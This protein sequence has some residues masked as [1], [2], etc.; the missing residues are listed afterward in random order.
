MRSVF[1]KELLKVGFFGFGKSSL[2]VYEYLKRHCKTE[3]TVRSDT[4]PHGELPPS[5]RLL[6][7][8]LAL[9]DIDEDILF[10]SPSVRRDR[11][12]LTKALER[13]VILSS[14]S[15]LFFEYNENDVYLVTGS[16][17]K[18]TTTYITAELLKN[19][20]GKAVPAGNFG[21]ALSPHIDDSPDTALVTELSSFQLNYFIPKSQRALITN[22]TEN[23]LNW[24]KSY[25]EYISA[26]KNALRLTDGAIL[27]YDNPQTRKIAHELSSLY[28]VFSMEK[29]EA[30]LKEEI[31]AEHYITLRDGCIS[32]S[33][34]PIL[35]IS[36][37][38]ARGRHN[39]LNFM[40]AIALS[41]GKCDREYI[42]NFAESFGGLVH[43]CETVGIYRGVRY[44]NSSIDSSPKRTVATLATFSD[45]VIIIL[46]GRGK[47]LDF[48]ELVPTLREKTKF[49]VLTG[50]CGK[51]IKEILD[52]ETRAGRF[53]APYRYESDFYDALDLAI[54]EASESDTVLLSPA[55]TSYDC[56]KSFEERGDAFK[57]YIKK[58]NSK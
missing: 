26:K 54:R 38:K 3:I 12:E 57:R 22:I 30:E 6:Y 35:P 47:G 9:T 21:E 33:G 13:G 23:H 58:R 25:E 56:F 46:G 28:S 53:C 37:I 24:H 14:D 32:V 42:E 36:K 10:L 15:E 19:H 29:S 4:R 2:G 34:E 8:N 27:S 5:S 52:T 1:D 17:G 31:K 41:Y 51:E 43:R 48:H 44:V 20:Y 40:S 16:D 11:P 55:S 18:S 39:I 49:I 7:G 45:K 50:E